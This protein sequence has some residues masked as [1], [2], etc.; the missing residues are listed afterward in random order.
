MLGALAG[1]LIMDI[2]LFWGFLAIGLVLYLLGPN[3]RLQTKEG[4]AHVVQCRSIYL[5][6]ILLGMN[7]ALWMSSGLLA[8]LIYLALD[9]IRPRLFLVFAFNITALLAFIMGTGL[10]TFSTIG[11]VFLSLSEAM[12]IPKALMVG[13]LVSGAF[14]AD[15]VSFSSAL[16]QLN[17]KVNQLNYKTFMKTASKTLIPSMV[18]TSVFYYLIP[19]KSHLN[20]GHLRTIQVLLRDNFT[21]HNLLLLIPLAF[22]LMSLRAWPSTVSLSLLIG[23]NSLVTLW[24]QQNDLGFLIEVLL[25]GYHQPHMP[26]FSGGGI[27]AM[28]EVIA[29]VM[30]AVFVTGQIMALKLFDPIF[31]R[32][33]SR[34]KTP[35]HLVLNT[36]LVSIFLTAITCDQTVGILLPGERLQAKYKAM[37]LDGSL[38]ARTISDTGVITAPLQFWN[39]NALIIS[40]LTGVSALAYAPYAFLC[41]LMP[42]VTYLTIRLKKTS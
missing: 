11:M 6:V 7:V 13:C 33:L 3:K 15:K 18:L 21:I 40:G 37:A 2:S 25:R 38:L 28:V 16:T 5:V 39:V 36:G 14:I 42:L 1:S 4:L 19:L 32:I 35:S 34:S 10:G 23:V 12:G 17:L 9:F 41:W 22:V 29:I 30:M 31:T 26:L 27:L 20:P 8:S 24:V